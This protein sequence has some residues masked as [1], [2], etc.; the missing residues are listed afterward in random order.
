MRKFVLCVIA[1]LSVASLHAPARGQSIPG[2]T[3]NG[4]DGSYARAV[5][6]GITIGIAS[7]LPFTFSANQGQSYDGIDVKVFEE[8]TKRLGITKVKWE[9]VQF[10]ALI[11]GLVSKRWDVVADNIHEN[12]RRLAVIAFTGPAYWYGSSLVVHTGN[13]TNVHTWELLAGHTVGTIRGSFSHQLLAE[14]KDLKEVMLYTTLDAE[15]ADLA[16]SRVDATMDDQVKILQFKK[17]N[18]NVPVEFASGYLPRPQ[19]NGYARYGVRKEDVD[20][21][22]AVSRA[23]AE[24]RADGTVGAILSNYGLSPRNLWY[25]TVPNSD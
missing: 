22:S 23:L 18:P 14:R 10:D 9:L 17:Q 13:P 7:D 8:L 19:D 11:P 21:N 3:F 2:V 12:E 4:G 16:A 15:M 5:K 20:L 24:M 1:L 6:D 25:F